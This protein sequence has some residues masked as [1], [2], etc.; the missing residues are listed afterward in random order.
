MLTQN[1]S[2]WDVLPVKSWI[3]NYLNKIKVEAK[4][5][6]IPLKQLADSIDITEEVLKSALRNDTLSINQLQIIC[7]E[8]SIDVGELFILERSIEMKL[9]DNLRFLS[10]KVFC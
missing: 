9:E 8:L 4:K 2:F 6:D 5:R 7:N 1:V 10:N 3:M